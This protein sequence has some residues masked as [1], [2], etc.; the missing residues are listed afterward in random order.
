MESMV[1][2]LI[3][4]SIVFFLMAEFFGRAKHIGRWW[5]FFL[6]L[7]GFF[8]GLIALIA[9]PSAK[10]Q[11][12][13]GGNGYKVWGI[14]L[15]IFGGLNFFMLIGSE[16]QMGQ[17][18]VAFLMTGFYLIQ[19][20]QGKVVNYD[21][22]FY[23]ESTSKSIESRSQYN[24]STSPP[25]FLGENNV[26]NGGESI[27]SSYKDLELLFNKG[28][29]TKYEYEQK[30]KSLK[31]SNLMDE[32]QKTNEFKSL[33]RL[34]NN[35][36]LE[37]YE[38]QNKLEVLKNKMRANNIESKSTIHK[39][40]KIDGDEYEIKD[41]LNKFRIGNYFLSKSDYIEIDNTRKQ[42]RDIPEL[43]EALKEYLPPN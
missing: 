9:S 31:E 13:K 35:K 16:G 27:S 1:V 10:N 37:D 20:S 14:I 33:T 25:P 28:V 38:Y 8:P 11:P 29:I 26:L 15:L 39:K 2:V 7:S 18:F 24:T 19:L 43:M 4:A 30:I 21:P 5:S 36:L 22:K 40:Y 12:T 17:A 34:Y 41:I 32:V 42:L 3:V 23:F 6:L